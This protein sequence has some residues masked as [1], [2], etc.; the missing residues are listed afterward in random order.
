MHGWVVLGIWCRNDVG[1]IKK[2]TEDLFLISSCQI[3]DV[4]EGDVAALAAGIMTAFEDSEINEFKIADEQTVQ[5]RFA[6]HF[7]DAFMRSV[8]KWYREFSYTDQLAS[9]SVGPTE[10]EKQVSL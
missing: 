6:K 3:D 9:W 4:N 10:V 8:I 1:I 7:I 2:A 5:Y